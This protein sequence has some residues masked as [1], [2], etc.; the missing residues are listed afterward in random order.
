MSSVPL[1]LTTGGGLEALHYLRHAAAGVRQTHTRRHRGLVD[2][3]SRTA[4]DH[5][6][7]RKF[8][9]AVLR[10]GFPTKNLLCVFCGNSVRCLK[11]PRLTEPELAVPL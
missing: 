9:F 6:F 7:H 10:R 11:L 5:S 2:I 3:Q 1:S 4:F 8:S